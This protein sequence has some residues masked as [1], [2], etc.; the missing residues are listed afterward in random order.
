M[1]GPKHL[2]SGDWEHES[3]Q[4]AGQLPPRPPAPPEPEPASEPEAPTIRQAPRPR[5][6]PEPRPPRAARRR[7]RAVRPG[8]KRALPFAAAALVIV[9][10]AVAAT[11]LI[12][13]SSPSKQAGAANP[14]TLPAAT[15][16]PGNGGPVS[17]LGMELVT[18]PPG[19][20][21]VITV[22]SG[23]AADRAG[24]EPGDVLLSIDGRPIAG[25][26]GITAAIRGLHSGD[27][28]SME[29]NHGSAQYQVDIT[30]G[31]PPTRSP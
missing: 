29:I 6:R 16:V 8:V 9:A 5:P 12:G 19:V 20:P 4:A 13:S 27:T 11:Q 22:Q 17:W 2:W 15:S 23:S 24:I 30:L 18:V 1:T 25:A 21:G 31:A 26:E 28:V 3:A 10:C 14:T 7:Q